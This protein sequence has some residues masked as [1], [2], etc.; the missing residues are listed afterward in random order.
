MIRRPWLV[1]SVLVLL[2]AVSAGAIVL[3]RDHGE[4]PAVA[5]NEARAAG[6]TLLIVEGETGSFGA[7][8]GS[9]GGEDAA[10]VVPA[11]TQLTIPGQGD[12]T[13]GD[14]LGLPPQDARTAVA[15]LLGVWVDHYV[16]LGRGRLAAAI[17][18]AGGIPVGGD[19]VSG[20]EAVGMLEGAGGGGTAAF[21]LVVN[22]LL[23]AEVPW[24]PKD[25]AKADSATAVRS[26]LEASAGAPVSALPVSEV[27]AGVV[28]ADPEDVRRTVVE[29][30][31][32]PDRE[33]VGVIVLNGSGVPGI[34]ALVADRIVPGGFRVVVSENAADFNHQETLIVVGS[35]DDVALGERVRDL[36]G[37]GS[38]N[39]SV[40]SGI[41]PVTIVV[42][43][44]FEG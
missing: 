14:A 18:R 28:Q 5:P 2:A 7:V 17:D 30:F 40:S 37:T 21:E 13:V 39:V 34:G 6:L 10:L 43:K 42:G 41:A 26:A 12:G 29:V 36:L 9:T 24:E 25:L 23:Q 15:N 32:G 27:A 22:G 19:T 16:V 11:E 44:D 4:A 38:V 3:T 1:L 20:D 35:A 31:G 33:V 8:L